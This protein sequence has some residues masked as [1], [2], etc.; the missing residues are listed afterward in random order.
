MPT[1]NNLLKG[2]FYLSGFSHGKWA[3][4]HLFGKTRHRTSLWK[5]AIG[6]FIRTLLTPFV[7]IHHQN[8]PQNSLRCPFLSVTPSSVEFGYA[9]RVGCL[10]VV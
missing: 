8:A 5:G 3:Q 9:T 1:E 7:P 6:A 2:E 10:S 4:S